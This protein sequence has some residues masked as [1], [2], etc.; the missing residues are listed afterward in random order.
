MISEEFCMDSV[1]QPMPPSASGRTDAS[2]SRLADMRDT[3]V[4][5][6]IHLMFRA[7]LIMRRW[8]Y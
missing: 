1:S 4:V 6:A 8:N 7:A 2:R 3:V 5:I